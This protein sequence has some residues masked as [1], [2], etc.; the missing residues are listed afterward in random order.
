MSEYI[1]EHLS[2]C[3]ER[4]DGKHIPWQSFV[5]DKDFGLEV[6]EYGGTA[7]HVRWITQMTLCRACNALLER[8]SFTEVTKYKLENRGLTRREV[9]SQL[10]AGNL[11][12]Q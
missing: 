7:T 3:P 6:K 12:L 1:Y 11:S 5:V 10:I 2:P 8:G 4:S 9:S